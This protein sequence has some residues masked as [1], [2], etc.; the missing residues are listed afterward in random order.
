MDILQRSDTVRFQTINFVLY[1]LEYKLSF[2]KIGF[3]ILLL[4]IVV[5]TFVYVCSYF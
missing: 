4:L 5:I 2:Y 3:F 1:Q